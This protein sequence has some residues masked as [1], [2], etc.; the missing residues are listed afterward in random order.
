MFGPRPVTNEK[1]GTPQNTRQVSHSLCSVFIVQFAV[2][3]RFA[4]LRSFARL[5]S[6]RRVPT[7]GQWLN[8][9]SAVRAVRGESTR[10]TRNAGIQIMTTTRRRESSTC[11]SAAQREPH[12]F[13]PPAPLLLRIHSKQQIPAGFRTNGTPLVTAAATATATLD[14]DNTERTQQLRQ[15]STNNSA[16]STSR[17]NG[18]RCDYAEPP[19]FTCVATD[20]HSSLRALVPLELSPVPR[21]APPIQIPSVDADAQSDSAGALP[22]HRHSTAAGNSYSESIS[23]ALSGSTAPGAGAALTVRLKT[24]AT[25]VVSYSN[26]EIAISS[27]SPDSYLHSNLN[28]NSNSGLKQKTCAQSV[29]VP[30][31]VVNISSS[32]TQSLVTSTSAAVRNDFR[33]QPAN[34]ALQINDLNATPRA[35]SGNLTSPAAAHPFA[36]R[37]T[38]AHQSRQLSRMEE[39]ALSMQR[40]PRSCSLLF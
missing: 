15:H 4:S 40:V 1:N 27:N 39:S 34:T 13:T 19:N 22:P 5:V 35:G 38:A 36:T 30:L 23:D 29:R 3:T 9:H 37:G 2:T 17:I 12:A 32:S 28:L 20:Q 6:S 10:T 7:G 11:A 8:I 33:S 14:S 26:A 31:T 24:I 25:P 16:S 21:V 18:I